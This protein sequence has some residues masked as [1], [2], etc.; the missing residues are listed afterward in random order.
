MRTNELVYIRDMI[1][2]YENQ[3]K[4]TKK[5]NQKTR[6][7]ER[8]KELKQKVAVRKQPVKEELKE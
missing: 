7:S 3:L 8:Q 5:R 2:E 4:K 1:E 6:R